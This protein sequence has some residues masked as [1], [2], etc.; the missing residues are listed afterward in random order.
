ALLPRVDG[1]SFALRASR[2]LVLMV[3]FA[4]FVAL[5]AQ[6]Q[7]RL[8]WTPVPVTGQTLGVLVAGGALG[9][10]RGAG[11]LTIYS[12]ARTAGLPLSTC[13]AFCGSSM[14]STSHSR[15]PSS[16]ACTRSSPVTS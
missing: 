5:L 3:A 6:F 7:V 9:A 4:G 13:P 16:S 12:L 1:N 8:P 10:W 11:S 15:S 2:Q 14:S